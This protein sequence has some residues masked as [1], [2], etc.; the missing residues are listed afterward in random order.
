MDVI[1]YKHKGHV[2]TK[3][4]TVLPSMGDGYLNLRVKTYFPN[5][6]SVIVMIAEASIIS[7]TK[8]K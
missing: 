8:E 5:N 2:I 7:Q 1:Q 4:G 3:K 6:G